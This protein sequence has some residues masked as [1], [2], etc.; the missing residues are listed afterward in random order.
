MALELRPSS[1]TKLTIML[2]PE[3]GSEPAESPNRN[4]ESPP[5]AGSPSDGAT[6]PKPSPDNQD[7]K[8]DDDGDTSK[9]QDG[10]GSGSA[11][12][13][14]NLWSAIQSVASNVAN[15]QGP[16]P[17]PTSGSSPGADSPANNPPVFTFQGQTLSPGNAATFGG[18]PVSELSGHDGV[19]VD[20]TQTVLVPDGQATT[21]Q[22]SGIGPF[23]VSRSGSVLIVNGQTL[24]PGQQVIAGQTTLSL[25]PSTGVL[26][27][28]GAATTLAGPSIT[29]G[30]TVY[31]AAANP[32][33][34]GGDLGG[35]IYS[36]IGGSPTP[37]SPQNSG[38]ANETGITPSTGSG[39]RTRKWELS[40]WGIIILAF[41]LM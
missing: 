17:T 33:T 5:S 36:G 19:V 24:S 3:P 34:S 2:A 18:S 28:N 35:Y 6:A 7:G 41:W 26:Y 27:V 40:S 32:S 20:G 29:I 25:A 10:S 21:I 31:T 14:G 22:Q 16:L 4:T 37:G 12:G 23:T 13:I 15:S 30:G 39:S 11:G 8:P 38:S 1:S 9:P